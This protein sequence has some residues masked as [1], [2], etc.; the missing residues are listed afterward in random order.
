VPLEPL[1]PEQIVLV[2]RIADLLAERLA[3]IPPKRFFGV[4]EAAAYCGL[5]PDSIR[6]LI[7]GGKLS[8]H[9]PVPGR[10]LIDRRELDSLIASSTAAPRGGR[11]KYHRGGAG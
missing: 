1:T 5:G 7:A 4:A 6:S 9:R 3:G 10:V 8:G 2:E 11:G